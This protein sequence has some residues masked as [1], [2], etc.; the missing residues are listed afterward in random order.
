MEGAAGA[1]PP[2]V[3]GLGGSTGLGAGGLGKEEPAA[4]RVTVGALVVGRFLFLA[5]RATSKLL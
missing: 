1:A 2:T 5:K 3:A 4:R